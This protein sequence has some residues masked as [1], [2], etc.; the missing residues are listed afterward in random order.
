MRILIVDDN[1]ITRRLFKDWL[2]P[3]R[4]QVDEAADGRE[5]LQQ[6]RKHRPNVVLLDLLM[7]VLDGFDVVDE[8]R[9][10]PEWRDIPV[11]VVTNKDIGIEERQRLTGRI[12]A[13]MAKYLL[14]ADQLREQLARLGLSKLPPRQSSPDVI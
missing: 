10:N 6:M 1:L 8:M 12:Q 7:P 3:E 14:T 9:K 2:E 11:I 4:I 13:I 5:A